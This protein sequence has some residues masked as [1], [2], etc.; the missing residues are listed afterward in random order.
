MTEEKNMKFALALTAFLAIL[1]AASAVS[2]C[3][4]CPDGMT[5]ISIPYKGLGMQN[6]GVV[7]Y[8]C[9]N[10][11]PNE[12]SAWVWM[13]GGTETYDVYGYVI[14]GRS[15]DCQTNEDFF[16]TI[17][18]INGPET[19]DDADAC[20][21]SERLEFL[22]TFPLNHGWNKIKMTSAAVC[23]PD[24]TANSVDLYKLCV[25]P[26]PPSAPEFPTPLAAVAVFALAPGIAYV[27]RKK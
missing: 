27:A 15:D 16:L 17:A 14:R 23:P 20:A 26:V 1:M 25:A 6:M 4:P 8:G 5:E 18:G 3:P 19:E 9:N 13:S 21:S 2:A 24:K 11:W 12:N 7:G 22:G 10:Y